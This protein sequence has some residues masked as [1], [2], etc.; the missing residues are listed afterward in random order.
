MPSPFVVQLQLAP[1]MVTSSYKRL[2]FIIPLVKKSTETPEH[3]L[4]ALQRAACLPTVLSQGICP[5][6]CHQVA[7]FTFLGPRRLLEH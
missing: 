3:L 2:V 4:N 5:E 1:G 6:I 7:L